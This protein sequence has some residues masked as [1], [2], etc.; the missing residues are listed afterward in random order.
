MKCRFFIAEWL[1]IDTAPKDGRWILVASYDFEDG[2]IVRAKWNGSHW[3]AYY[4]SGQMI[5]LD[6]RL[7]MPLPW[8]P[9]KSQLATKDTP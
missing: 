5:R 2:R 7:W 6:A 3:V 8:I 1:P 4:G 9:H